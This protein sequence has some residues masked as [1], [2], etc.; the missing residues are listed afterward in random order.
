[1]GAMPTAR[2]DAKIGLD[3]AIV[4]VDPV[5][6]FVAVGEV[7][8]ALFVGFLG[9]GDVGGEDVNQDVELGEEGVVSRIGREGGGGALLGAVDKLFAELDG[10][11][12]LIRSGD[13][14]QAG[15]G[16]SGVRGSG[17]YGGA[18]SS[19]ATARGRGG[20]SAK[21]GGAA[22]FWRERR[23]DELL[24]GEERGGNGRGAS[25]WA[26]EELGNVP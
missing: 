24:S 16:C 2:L 12:E 10:D 1:M 4:G 15:H 11:V 23:R 3:A 18:V 5:V 6:G 8:D 26:E 21:R 22:V 17:L 9:A 25:I 19:D 7:L 13:A 14:I 20:E